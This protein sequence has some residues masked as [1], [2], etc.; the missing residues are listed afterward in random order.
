MRL[1]LLLSILG[2]AYMVLA[3]AGSALALSG[4]QPL[5]VVLCKFTDQTDEPRNVQYFQD[6]F[7]ETGAGESNVFDFWR[8]VSYGNLD[9]TGTVV[10]GW[11]TAP[12]TAAQFNVLSRPDQIDTCATQADNE[13]D[14]SKFAGVVVLT[15]HTNFNGPLFGGGP[16]TP[17]NG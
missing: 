14:F 10:K 12:K 16:P 2:A 11:Y 13:V 3:L 15:N 5:V 1:R 17:I 7:S 9:L 8:D 4:K 6:L